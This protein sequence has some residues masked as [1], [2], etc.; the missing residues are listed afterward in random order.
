MFHS[1]IATPKPSWF[2]I[3]IVEDRVEVQETFDLEV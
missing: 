2:G 3:A 1:R